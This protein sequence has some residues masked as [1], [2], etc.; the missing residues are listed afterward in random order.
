MSYIPVIFLTANNDTAAEV[1]GLESGA[2]DFITKPVEKSILLHR[3]RIHLELYDYQNDLER[4]LV[5]IENNIVVSFA[6]LIE[7]KDNNT[8]GHVLRTSKYV[9]LI[10]R[11]LVQR[12]LFADALTVDELELMVQAAP[13]HDIGKIGISDVILLKAGPL[14]DDEYTIAKQHTLI[15]SRILAKIYERTPSRSYLRYAIQMA[16]GHHEKWDGT[17]YPRGLRGEEIPLCCRIIA[18]AN[19]Y[20]GCLTDRVYRKALSQEE[21]MKVIRDGSGKS[22]DPRIAGIMDENRDKLLE[23]AAGALQQ[24]PKSWRRPTNP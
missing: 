18:V 21:S 6:E 14:N 23:L 17:G 5:E 7:S 8:G 15:G 22:F 20:D 19:V 1:R 13:F 3:I 10:G 16:E 2:V 12:G 9:E 24:I 11:D 4:T